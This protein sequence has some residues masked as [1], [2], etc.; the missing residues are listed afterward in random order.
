MLTINL[1]IDQSQ[2][3]KAGDSRR[4]F[5]KAISGLGLACAL[6][7]CQN[8]GKPITVA[9]HT[10]VGY[11]PMFLA[12]REGWLDE[13]QVRLF[14]TTTATESMQA[15]AE[16]KV[17][18][19]ALTLDEVFKVRQDGQKLTVVM[20]YD[21]SA[22]ADMLLARAGIES[23]AGLKGQRIGY[24]QSSVGELLLSETLNAAGLK[25]D[26]VKLV[27]LSVDKHRDAWQSNALDAAVTYEPVA[28][29][30]LALG[31]HKLFD[32]RQIPNTIIDV[33]AMRTDLLE[34]HASAIRHLTKIHVKALDH[35]T[36][37]PQDAAYRMA[38]HLKLKASDV[39]PAFKGLLL[40]DAA[41][42][43]RLMSGATPELLATAGKLAAVMVK[44]QLLK[45]DDSL[46]SLISADFL[47]IDTPSK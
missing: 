10:W 15:L 37:N 24:E 7:G 12:Q 22:G 8:Q 14:E 35:L 18:G 5:I 28:S 16:G 6:P 11:E 38:E 4:C 3:L 25:R 17:D 1:K 34:S 23:L 29:E 42:N 47:P 36:R 27:P 32:S 40:P 31:A 44:N 30:L 41:Y 43:R 9:A 39:M 45:Q 33:L 2:L 19:A 20:I 13:K 46:N 26:D 21:I